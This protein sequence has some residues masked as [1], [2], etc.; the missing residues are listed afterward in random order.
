MYVR[1]NIIVEGQTEE[2][3]VNQTL[4]P[5]LSRFSVGVSARVVTTSKQRGAKNRG[6]LSNYA[7]ARRDIT[8]WTKQDRNPD[9]RFTTMFDLY[10]LPTDFPGYAVA[11]QNDPFQRVEALEDALAKDISD[12]RFIPYIQLHEFEALILSD[13]RELDSQFDNRAKGIARLGTM[14]SQFPS[15]EHINEGTNTAPSKRI[16]REVPEYEGSKVS[17]GPIVAAKI[18]LSTLRSKCA[19]LSGWL[20]K[21]EGL[22]EGD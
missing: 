1:L 17:A 20:D 9:V 2:T 19:H 12:D 8:L 3:F 22:A 14:V 18:G 11:L 16:I 10:G 21:L 13:P 5:H 6:G 4:K 15:P 7:K